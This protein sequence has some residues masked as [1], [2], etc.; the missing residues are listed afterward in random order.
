MKRNLLILAGI[1]FISVLLIVR[2]VA[3][4]QTRLEAEERWFVQ[5]LG[6]EFSVE[7]DSVRKYENK[8]GRVWARI[9]EGNPKMYREDSLKNHFKNHEMLYFIFRHSGDS[10]SFV[11]PD[12]S[13]L[14]TGDS[15]RISSS[16]D[17]VT[18]FHENKI[19]SQIP[20]SKTV[21]G[22]GASPFK[23]DK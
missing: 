15:I 14:H 6:Y 12:A 19:V 21:V 18:V 5:S 16:K 22:W 9:T 4:H 8:G 20:F 3:V 10:V 11:L 13:Q 2:L 17:S 1:G 7:V 23:R